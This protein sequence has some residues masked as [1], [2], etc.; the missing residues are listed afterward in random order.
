MAGTHDETTK[1]TE[2]SSA[3]HRLGLG[4]LRKRIV[5]LVAA[6]IIVVAAVVTIALAM[7]IVFVGFSAN[8]DNSIVSFVDDWATRFAWKF[9]DMFTPKDHR[10]GV[11]VNFGIAGAVYLI[12]GRIVAGLVRRLG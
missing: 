8:Q 9:R 7:H 10:V 12:A 2:S 11:L 3:G 6:L 4:D 1:T 5:R